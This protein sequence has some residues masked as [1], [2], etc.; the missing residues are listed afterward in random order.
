[1][2]GIETLTYNP[3]AE[4]G[5]GVSEWSVHTRMMGILAVLPT[6]RISQSTWPALLNVDKAVISRSVIKLNERG[7]VYRTGNMRR[8]D[9]VFAGT[10]SSP[11]YEAT[12]EFWDDRLTAESALYNSV[13]PVHKDVYDSA[14]SSFAADFNDTDDAP[15]T[16]AMEMARAQWTG[17]IN[18]LGN[19]YDMSLGS[20]RNWTEKAAGIDLLI[21][22]SGVTTPSSK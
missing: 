2:A 22:T 1:M 5:R 10:R 3:S 15:V 7:W 19:L 17:A 13:T 16:L 21:R 6:R 12:D 11:I 18:R 9:A 20:R 4:I 14:C 8:S